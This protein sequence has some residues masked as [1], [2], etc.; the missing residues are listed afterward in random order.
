MYISYFGH[1]R[2]RH[3]SLSVMIN[4]TKV[5]HPPETKRKAS[6][7]SHHTHGSSLKKNREKRGE[8]DKSKSIDDGQVLLFTHAHGQSI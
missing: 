4:H 7:M 2:T 3:Q 5:H 1:T 6:K 8:D